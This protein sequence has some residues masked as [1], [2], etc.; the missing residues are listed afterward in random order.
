MNT[1][2]IRIL[3][4]GTVISS[5]FLAIGIFTGN[6]LPFNGCLITW[7]AQLCLLVSDM[8]QS[9]AQAPPGVRRPA[10]AASAGPRPAQSQR[11]R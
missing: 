6:S 2:Q 9:R 8:Q 1:K 5:V 7:A 10:N 4:V 11:R 3:L